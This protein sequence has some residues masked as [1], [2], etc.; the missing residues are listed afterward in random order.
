MKDYVL[1]VF[2]P[3]RSVAV[4]VSAPGKVDSTMEGLR[5][6]G[7]DVERREVEISPEELEEMGSEGTESGSESED[8]EMEEDVPRRILI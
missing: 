4:I 3:S 5:E 8:S 1:P 2:D 6:L 7:F